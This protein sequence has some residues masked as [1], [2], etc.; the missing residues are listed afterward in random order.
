MKGVERKRLYIVATFEPMN[1]A[2]KVLSNEG[3]DIRYKLGSVMRELWVS[4][5]H[6]D[7]Y[8]PGGN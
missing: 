4:Q 8:Q 2:P 6:E 3:K 5:S 7:L 1:N